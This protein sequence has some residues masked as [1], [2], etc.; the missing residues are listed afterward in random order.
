MA[1][2][3]FNKKKASFIR[4]FDLKVETSKVLYLERSFVRCSNLDTS[5]IRSDMS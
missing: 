2:T 1:K 5:E 3:A 4:K